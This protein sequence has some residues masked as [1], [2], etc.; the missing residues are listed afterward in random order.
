[1][2]LHDAIPDNQSQAPT[3]Y[4]GSANPAVTAAIE[5]AFG[6]DNDFTGGYAVSSAVPTIEPSDLADYSTSDY[7]AAI[8]GVVAMAVIVY[9]AF[10][11]E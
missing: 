1:M 6:A 3:G 11:D 7:G 4:A 8:F 9:F 5:S 10:Q 2:Y